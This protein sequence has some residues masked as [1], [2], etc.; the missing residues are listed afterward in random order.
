MGCIDD[1][2]DRFYAVFGDPPGQFPAQFLAELRRVMQ[3]QAPEVVVRTTDHWI[4]NRMAW[5][6]PAE[7]R[8]AAL[9]VATALGHKPSVHL[10]KSPE[11]KERV[12][13]LTEQFRRKVGPSCE[14]NAR[15]YHL[16]T[17]RKPSSGNAS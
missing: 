4:A 13:A 17:A 9:R 8:L 5:P 16:P 14:T 6:R 15:V 10:R 2:T 12:E 11:S 1:M 3:T 7:L